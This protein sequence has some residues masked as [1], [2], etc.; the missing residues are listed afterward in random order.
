MCAETICN[1]N[2]P[3][4]CPEPLYWS[5]LSSEKLAAPPWLVSQGSY[6]TC[7]ETSSVE[8]VCS[9]PT[10]TGGKPETYCCRGCTDL[11][12]KYRISSEFSEVTCYQILLL[13]RQLL[14]YGNIYKIQC[15][16]EQC[17]LNFVCLPFFFS[18]ITAIA[19]DVF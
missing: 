4:E 3:E 16:Q 7:Q 2:L 13:W 17:F 15:E 9:D 11:K 1:H 19:K 8:K 18:E 5:N 12:N 6:M 10:E 14:E